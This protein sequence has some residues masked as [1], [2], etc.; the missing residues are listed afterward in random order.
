MCH[1]I[2]TFCRF[3]PKAKKQKPAAADDD[4][5]G[6]KDDDATKGGKKVFPARYV[7]PGLW[8]IKDAKYRVTI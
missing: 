7:E 6:Q 3:F 2:K 5:E 8:R 4:D 1:V